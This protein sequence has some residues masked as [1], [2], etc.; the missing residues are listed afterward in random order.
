[1]VLEVIWPPAI[2]Y[3]CQLLVECEYTGAANLP[4][5][6]ADFWY[7]LCPVLARS[8]T[9]HSAPHP[10]CSSSPWGAEEG[11]KPDLRGWVRRW[12]DLDAQREPVLHPHSTL[13]LSLPPAKPPSPGCRTVPPPQRSSGS[14]QVPRCVSPRPGCGSGGSFPGHGF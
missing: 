11:G 1:M 4:C 3:T 12:D 10:S 7:P 9:A 8:S 2:P 13:L 5:C 6:S 14:R